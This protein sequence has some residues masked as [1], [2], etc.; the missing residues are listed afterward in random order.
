MFDSLPLAP[1]DAILGLGEAFKSDP[2]PRK[3][4]LSV[5]VYK[6]EQGNTP[7][8]ASVKEAER[9]LLA[10]EKTK[11]YLSIEGHPEYDAR[12]QQMLF[13]PDHEV[14]KSKRAI[15]AQTPGGTGSLRVAADFLKKH[16]PGTTVWLS[17][18]TWANHGAIFTAAGLPV[19]SY[20]YID[21]AGRGLDFPAMLAA[22]RKIPAG[23]VVLL[24]ACCHN[25]TGIDPA[26]DQ[27]REIA[28]VIQERKLLPLVDFAYQGF[29][30]GLTQ[31]AA[32]LLA[33]A[34]PG[35]ELLVCSSFSKN[36][37][38]YGERVGALTVV[39]QNADAATRALSQVRIS[40]RTNYSNPP[41]HGAAIVAA[42]L[43]DSEL[44]RQWEGELAAMRDRIHQMRRLF[45]ETMREKAPQH[46]FSFLIHQKGMFSFS[47]LSNLQVDELKTKHAVYVVGNGGRM[48]V[49]G[50][51]RENMEPLCTAIAAVL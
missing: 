28:A 6:D 34:Q 37:G 10:S 16:F 23:D 24:H 27:W 18:P 25:P 51:T 29:G 14:L 33:L 45:V 1:P 19:E 39:A 36:F 13:G 44:R 8:L 12:V 31:D 9:R 47:G 26:T 7:I 35:Q 38:L 49:A 41:T 20:A 11:G 50:M 48:N 32:G 17:K 2:N 3:I 15:T 5:G 42:V 30:E 22:L 21:A 40:I 46:D 43:S 4:N